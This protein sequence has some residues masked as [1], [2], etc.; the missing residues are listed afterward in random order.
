MRESFVFH[1]EYIA[2]LPEEYKAN[3]A[4]YTISY[5]LSGEKPPIREGSLEWALWVK[6]ARRIDQ[7]SEK[8]ESIKAKRAAA[9]AKAKLLMETYNLTTA[10]CEFVFAD[11]VRPS[12]PPHWLVAI[13]NII[14]KINSCI[15]VY[16]SYGK[17]D[18]N[19]Q[20]I[21]R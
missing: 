13:T 15:V 2:D 4:M 14:E 10:D 3:F 8:Y 21:W 17:A 11:V 9:L 1:S 6:I 18:K 12:T 20:I 19:L 5:A 7:E 16:I